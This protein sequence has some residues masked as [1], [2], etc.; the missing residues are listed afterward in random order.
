MKNKSTFFKTLF[1]ASLG[2]SSQVSA[3]TVNVGVSFAIPPYVIQ[4]ENS[5]LELD[6]LRQALARRGHYAVIHYMPLS[7]TF[8]EIKE[9]KLDGIINTKE[10]MLDGVFYSDEVIRFHNCVISLASRNLEINSIHDLKGMS[11]VAFQQAGRILGEEFGMTVAKS[12]SYSEIA[13][14][15]HQIHLLFKGRTDVIVMEKNIFAYYRKKELEAG[16]LEAGLD[17][18]EA[19]I[20][21][22]T[23]YRFAFRSVRIR[24]D[25]NAGLN[26]MREDGTL[27]AILQKYSTMM[28]VESTEESAEESQP[29]SGPERP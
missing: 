27:K 2:A 17:V 14:Q 5:G 16:F 20:F 26:S 3:E 9:G 13:A 19:C 23:A 1:L 10:H 29:Q 21:E 8:R 7:R 15:R 12:P 22:P 24:D 18:R 6:I 4:Q 28:H 11:V 25:F